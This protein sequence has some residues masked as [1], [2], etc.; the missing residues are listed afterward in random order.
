VQAK[1]DRLLR[2]CRVPIGLLSNGAE[3]RLTYA[4]IDGASGFIP[5]RVADMLQS[6]GRPILDAFLMLLEAKRWFGVRP[7]DRLPEMLKES[8]QRQAE[9]TNELSRQVF[10]ALEIL[11][12]GFQAAA[13]RDGAEQSALYRTLESEE[14]RVYAGLL[15][16][17]LRL[18]FLLYC[19]DHRLLPSEHELFSRHYSLLGLFEQLQQDNDRTPDSMGQRFG[20]YARLLALFRLVYLGGKHTGGEVG[21][22]SGA[23]LGGG[24]A[25]GDSSAQREV[26]SFDLP[27]RRGEVFDPNEYPFLEGWGPGGSAPVASAEPT[28]PLWLPG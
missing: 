4:P 22:A 2:E 20:A 15:T 8:R 5:F 28:V 3:L 6:D 27:E 14:E 7:E 13:D 16:V 12:A 17:L 26:A 18:V 10:E 24:D 21:A 11:L 19:E 1:F 25:S 23:D 9:V